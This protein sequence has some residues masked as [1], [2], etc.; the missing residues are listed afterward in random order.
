MKTKK[1][2]KETRRTIRKMKYGNIL[3]IKKQSFRRKKDLTFCYEMQKVVLLNQTV[4]EIFFKAKS[5]GKN[6]ARINI[7]LRDYYNEKWK[8]F[9]DRKK[10]IFGRIKILR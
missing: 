4:F 3:D 8:Y 10:L 6:S 1:E 9:S 2:M 7:S 5:T